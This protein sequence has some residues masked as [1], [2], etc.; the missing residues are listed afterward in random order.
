MAKDKETVTFR[1]RYPALILMIDA[2]RPIFRPDGSQHTT[3]G[4]KAQFQ[5]GLLTTSDPAVIA[6]VKSRP[7]FG[8]DVWVEGQLPGASE[9]VIAPS[10]EGG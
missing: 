3:E 7:Y 9:S 8:A 4:K 10:K 2:P 1:S 6:A 5:D